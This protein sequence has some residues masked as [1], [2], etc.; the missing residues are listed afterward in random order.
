MRKWLD[1]YGPWIALVVASVA[2]YRRYLSPQDAGM[3]LYPQ[4]A[5][6]LID[7]AVRRHADGAAAFRLVRHHDRR[8]G[9]RL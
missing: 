7:N 3:L 1:R 4:A 8:D 9:R 5:Q 6:C 2:Y